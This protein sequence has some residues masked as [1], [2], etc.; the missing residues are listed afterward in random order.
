MVQFQNHTSPIHRRTTIS[1]VLLLR[2]NA[3]TYSQNVASRRHSDGRGRTI[4]DESI[5]PV[6]EACSIPSL[7]HW[8]T[9]QCGN[10]ASVPTLQGCTEVPTPFPN[11]N[12]FLL[13]QFCSRTGQ[14]ATDCRCRR[15]MFVEN[16]QTKGCGT[17][18]HYARMKSNGTNISSQHRQEGSVAGGQ[19]S[20]S[21]AIM[22]YTWIQRS[23][24][25]LI[26]LAR[27]GEI[28]WTRAR[29]PPYLTLLGSTGS[30]YTTST[31][32]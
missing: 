30:A 26:T 24:S 18:L 8:V 20:P 27:R 21:R 16:G 28:P 4:R 13:S 6:R 15:I 1:D 12:F 25:R 19:I 22:A 14:I 7:G 2:S 3:A 5:A 11:H 32:H 31:G 29:R 23:I 17:P 10:G 9:M